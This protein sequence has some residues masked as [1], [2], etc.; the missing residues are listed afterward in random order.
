MNGKA[1]VVFL[2]IPFLV[3]IDYSFL[4]LEEAVSYYGESISSTHPELG[5]FIFIFLIFLIIFHKEIF[6]YINKLKN[7]VRVRQKF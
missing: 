6:P 1:L 2:I 4:D 5:S 7:S 3:S